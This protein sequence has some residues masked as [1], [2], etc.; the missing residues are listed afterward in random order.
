MKTLW[1]HYQTLTAPLVQSVCAIEALTNWTAFQL[2][3]KPNLRGAFWGLRVI[4]S[5]G[6]KAN[7]C[8]PN[9]VEAYYIGMGTLWQHSQTLSAPLVQSL[10]ARNTHKLDRRPWLESYWAQTKSEGS[11]L[12]GMSDPLMWEQDRWLLPK[13]YRVLL[14]VQKHSAI[15]LCT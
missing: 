3:L 9:L 12:G 5:G 7:V 2:K 14:K 1:Q 6:S 10:C 11:I 8:Y 4:C 13:P 15:T